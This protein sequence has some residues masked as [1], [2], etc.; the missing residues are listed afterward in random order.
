M[1]KKT[2]FCVFIFAMSFFVQAENDTRMFVKF[3]EMMQ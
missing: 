2:A 1:L 3:P